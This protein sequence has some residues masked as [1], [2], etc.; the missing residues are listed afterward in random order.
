MGIDNHPIGRKEAAEERRVKAFEMRKAGASF[1]TIGTQL[2]ISEA[3]AYTDVQ[4]VL[5]RLVTQS[6]MLAEEYVA[7]ECERLDLALIAVA[8]Q[9]KAGHLGA[10]DRWI[11]L[12]ESRRKLLGLD[13]PERLKLLD[14]LTDDELR[15]LAAGSP[16]QTA[17]TSTSHRESDDDLPAVR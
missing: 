15:T 3:Q 13:A 1:R 11:K 7:L 8:R 6:L 9:V 14:D 12:S 16:P 2:G 17:A 4:T 5:Q 10:I